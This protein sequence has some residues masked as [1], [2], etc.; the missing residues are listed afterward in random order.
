MENHRTGQEEKLM[1][2]T[3]GMNGVAVSHLSRAQPR[4]SRSSCLLALAT[5]LAIALAAAL[6]LY[7]FVFAPQHNQVRNV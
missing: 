4:R 6:V 3:V 7:F 2:V 1:E 5:L